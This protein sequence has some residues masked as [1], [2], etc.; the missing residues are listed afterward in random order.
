MSSVL[1][2]SEGRRICKGCREPIYKGERCIQF[3]DHFRYHMIWHSYCLS[4]LKEYAK[5]IKKSDL[6]KIENFVRWNVILKIGG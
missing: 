2:T 1:I 5:E 3:W 4:C 6:R